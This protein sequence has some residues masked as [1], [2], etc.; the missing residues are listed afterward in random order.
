MTLFLILWLCA[1]A[2]AAALVLAYGVGLEPVAP[3]GPA[4]R[5]AVLV[6]V[7]G[8]DPE[9]DEFLARLFAQEYPDFRV[10]FAVETADDPALGGIEPYRLAHPDRVTVVV[11][12][13][14]ADEGQK[15]TNLIAGI[16]A[17]RPEDEILVLADADI[18]PQRDWL[19]RLVAPLV[20]GTA[21]IVTGFPWLV[22]KDGKV[23]S[24][25][26][27]SL[28]ASVATIPRLP[29]LNGVW[30]GTAALRQEHFQA[31]DM[32]RHW[33]G[34]LSDDLQLT[35]VAQACGDRI[36]VPREMLLRTALHTSGFGE[37]IAEARR[38]YMLVRIH[39]PIAYFGTVIA[40]SFGALGW[41]LA[42]VGTI[43]GRGDAAAVL[44]LAVLVSAARTLGRYRLVRALWGEA[45]VAE[46]LSFLRID[47]LIAPLA[48]TL[49]ALCG[50]SAL[51]LHR[52]TWAGTTYEIHGPQRVKVISRR[53]TPHV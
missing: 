32:R 7:K 31:L 12:G 28:A 36:A 39:M 30:G 44:A 13:L 11:A 14:G 16:D 37:I 40:M 53:G 3:Q 22:V 43:A 47:W 35:N 42:I 8:R 33:R 18:W 38:W 23:S 10:I 24:Y 17:L 15:T 21:D 48:V 19:R 6:A 34:T 29:L 49:N 50:W 1:Q 9:F 5:V 20:R 52:T 27:T 45:G 2:V 26:L 46:N 25:I 41:I 4:P 51:F